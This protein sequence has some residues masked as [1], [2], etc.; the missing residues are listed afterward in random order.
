MHTALRMPKEEVLE[1]DGKD[2][3]K[4]VHQVLDKIKDFSSRVRDGKI[5]GY[6]GKK[7]VNIVAIGVGGSDFGSEF[8]YEALRYDSKAREAS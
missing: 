6:S 7:L 5:L 8:I 2:V 4:E 1:V 3:V